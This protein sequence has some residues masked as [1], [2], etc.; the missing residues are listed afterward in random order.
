MPG[1]FTPYDTGPR[2]VRVSNADG[3][4]R[5]LGLGG[6]L[7]FTLDGRRRTLQVGVE[8]DGSLWAVFADATSGSTSYRVPCRRPRR[9]RRG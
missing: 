5:G 2:S 9:S 7:A 3:R 1:R 6:E 4:E 8:A